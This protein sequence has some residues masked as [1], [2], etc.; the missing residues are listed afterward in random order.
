MSIRKDNID[1]IWI[2]DEEFKGI[3][4]QGLLTVN[5]KTYVVSPTRANDGSIPN[6]NDYDTF[7]VPRAKVN[8]KL[9][10][11]EDYQRLCRVINLANEFPVRYFDKQIG[12]FVTHYM[13]CEPEE[14]HKLFN[15]GNRVIGLLDYEISFIGTLNSREEY[16]VTYYLNSSDTDSST[17]SVASYK[18]G[19]SMVVLTGEELV[20]IAQ[21][22]GFT[23]PNR[24]FLGWNTRRDGTGITYR[25]NTSASI[26]ETM[27]LYAIWG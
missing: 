25:P 22:K 17:L 9:F 1:S 11:I 23:I 20:S 8:F 7:T 15:V 21:E 27:N 14:M 18:W 12:D 10:E 6:I 2:W 26:F 3:G 5:T 16:V 24:T 19:N 13:Y 4:Y